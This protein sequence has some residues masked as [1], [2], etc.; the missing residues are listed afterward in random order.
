MAGVEAVNTATASRW[1]FALAAVAPLLSLQ[2][3]TRT[4]LPTS[5][6]V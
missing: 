1:L 3:L 2:T 4:R 6:G 5:T